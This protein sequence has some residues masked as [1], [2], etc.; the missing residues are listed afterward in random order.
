MKILVSTDGSALSDKAIATAVELAAALQAGLIGMT[1][2]GSYAYSGYADY[3]SE[4]ARDETVFDSE[5][6]AAAND[7]LAAVER[8]ATAAGIGYELVMSRISP[9]W[10]AIIDCARANDCQM[11]VMASHGRSGLGALV[12]GSETQKVL[13]HGDRPVLV[14]R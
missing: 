4:E 10:Q 3:G 5:Q 13:A 2:V 8:A 6:A 11:I 1:A 7:R 14:V 9:P 12:L